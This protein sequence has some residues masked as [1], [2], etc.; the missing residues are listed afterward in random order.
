MS[1]EIKFKAYTFKDNVMHNVS[2]TYESVAYLEWHGP[3]VGRGTHYVNPEFDKWEGEPRKVD[4]VMLQYTGLKDKKGSEAYDGDRLMHPDYGKGVIEW[5]DSQAG[6]ITDFN[7]GGGE[8]LEEWM[9]LM[10][11]LKEC[12]IIGNIYENK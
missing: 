12:E 5:S 2:G 6:F 3:G 1:R 4:S 7:E 8:L 9:F 10:D 11:V